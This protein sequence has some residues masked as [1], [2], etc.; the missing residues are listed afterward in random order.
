[1]KVIAAS[2]L[3][4]ISFLLS[5]GQGYIDQTQMVLDG[6]DGSEDAQISLSSSTNTIT[7]TNV[8]ITLVDSLQ[9]GFIEFTVDENLRQ[10][11]QFALY[12]ELA[13][14]QAKDL[15][16]A[17]EY[18]NKYDGLLEWMRFNSPQKRLAYM[19]SKPEWAFNSLNYTHHS[20]SGEQ[21]LK[22]AISVYPKEIIRHY[23]S[24]AEA[25]YSKDLLEKAVITNPV[26]AK[27]YFT[28]S[29]L[30][31]K[32][33][34][35][36]DNDTIEL[37]LQF[38]E[39]LP[40]NTKAYVLS[41]AIYRGLILTNE[42]KSIYN[43]KDASY[44]NSLIEIISSSKQIAY[45]AVKTE[46]SYQALQY[47]RPINNLHE[48]HD[49]KAR[50]SSLKKFDAKQLYI[51]MVYSEE[52]IFTSSF[53]GFYEEFLLQMKQEGLS[54]FELLQDINFHGFRTFLKMCAGYGLLNDFM[55]TLTIAEKEALLDKLIVD[56]P[57]NG[58]SIQE[59]VAIAETIGSI[60]DKETLQ[61]IGSLL[62]KAYQ[63]SSNNGVKVSY[64]LLI[65]LYQNKS[66]I[67]SAYF[68]SIAALYPTKE[69]NE[70]SFASA[71]GNDKRHTQ[72]HFF[73]NDDDG[74][75]SY[76][77]FLSYF[78][79]SKWT[80]N[81]EKEY[82][83]IRSNLGEEVLIF[84]NKPG[85]DKTSFLVIKDTLKGLSAD[86]DMVVHRGHSYHVDKTMQQIPS[87]TK[88]ILLGSCGG[89]HRLNDVLNK[90]PDVHIISTKQIGSQY[91]NNPMLL[92]L[93]SLIRD[94]K[95]LNW[96]DVWL[97]FERMFP[98]NTSAGNKF[99][100]YIGPHQ[101]MGAQF[102]QSYHQ[103]NLN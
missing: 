40:R 24:F 47:V 82:V 70:L 33:L 1:M 79:N 100:E 2:I 83:L 8:F 84:A 56:L 71:L 28:N 22:N 44:L 67:P 41:D 75:M 17:S 64:G 81:D 77:S 61:I 37:F 6:L 68:D 92:S 78:N 48:M 54:G 3:A 85:Y 30:L 88:I 19:L 91:V 94:G 39:E 15:A 36:S 9:S 12:N 31:Y 55:S 43:A 50:F 72:V 5:F 93:A 87:S 103:L 26:A 49:N 13:L 53:N 21:F 96:S 74:I 80:T 52:E 25:S 38:K 62:T 73:Y 35:S 42:V 23:P 16:N 29:Y 63:E 32:D 102:I 86:I 90:A 51:L 27:K 10:K 18:E 95:D 65:N 4:C 7:A 101:N 60:E 11:M 97:D 98:S 20:E 57:K 45:A 34:S 59:A 69:L 89:Y 66:A 99:K 46:L 14:V 76:Q 58:T